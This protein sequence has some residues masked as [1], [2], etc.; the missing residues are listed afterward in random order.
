MPS[1]LRTVLITTESSHSLQLEFTILIQGQRERE[2][3]KH[4]L[5]NAQQIERR[6]MHHATIHI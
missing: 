5:L 3:H 4:E 2:V 6:L 1:N